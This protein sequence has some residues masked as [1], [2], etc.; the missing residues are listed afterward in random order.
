VLIKKEK[1]ELMRK[2]DELDKKAE[3]HLLSQHE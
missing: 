1:R 2:V 3:T